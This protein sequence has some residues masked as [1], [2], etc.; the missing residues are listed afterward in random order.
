MRNWLQNGYNEDSPRDMSKSS[1]KKT[2]V[3]R[4]VISRGEP[5]TKFQSLTFGDLGFLEHASLS[6]GMAAATRFG[7]SRHPSFWDCFFSGMA[8]YA[9]AFASLCATLRKFSI[10][11]FQE[12]DTAKVATVESTRR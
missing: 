12:R 1:A 2:L 10:Y 3:I 5:I 6:I 11:W 4:L 8:G 7:R 9:E